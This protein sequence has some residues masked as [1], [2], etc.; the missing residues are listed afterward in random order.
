[1]SEDSVGL[2]AL[3][4]AVVVGVCVFFVVQWY[5]ADLVN[6]ARDA[7]REVTSEN[8]ALRAAMDA[9]A[10]SDEAILIRDETLRALDAKLLALRTP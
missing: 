7:A 2:I 3:A 4:A 6:S 9:M 10:V 5:Y 8:V 1:M